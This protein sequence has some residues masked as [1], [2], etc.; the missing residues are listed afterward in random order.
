MQNNYPSNSS[1]YT[2]AV[3]ARLPDTIAALDVAEEARLIN[4]IKQQV[5]EQDA[6]IIAH[7]YT[8]EILQ[9]LAEMTH[10]FVGDSLAM[11]QFGQ[12]QSA[13]KLIIAGVKFMGETAKILNPEKI[14]LMPTLAATCSLDLNCPIDKFS[15]FCAQYPDRTIV[16]YANTSAAVKARADWVVTSSIALPIIKYLQERGEKILW[17]SDKHLGAYLQNKTNADMIFWDAACVVH[18]EFKANYL[19]D[20]QRQH[21]QAAILAHPES[22]MSVL[23]IADIIGSTSQLINAAEKLPHRTLLV[24]TEKGIFYK[25]RAQVPNKR[26]ILAPTSG[27]GANCRSCGHCPWMKMNTLQA[28]TDTLTN[29]SNQI[30]VDEEIRQRALVS[31]QRMINFAAAHG[32]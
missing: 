3:E 30:L 12:Q 29:H 17:A 11:A 31:V 24:A 9:T 7:Y 32:I 16:V 19:L 20:L 13:K 23:N 5:V 2:P 10:G 15:A 21:P 14:V 1:N 25:M 8:P 22:P 28:V 18:E 26:L 6:A 4:K 27:V